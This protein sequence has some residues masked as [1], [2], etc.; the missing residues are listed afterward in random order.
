M[1]CDD[2]MN[3]NQ[4][5]ELALSVRKQEFFLAQTDKEALFQESLLSPN[6]KT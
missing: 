1:S 3:N 5:F 4:S 6:N 2:V